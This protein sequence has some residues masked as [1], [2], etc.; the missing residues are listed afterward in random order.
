[1]SKFSFKILATDGNARKGEISTPRGIIRTPAFMPVGTAATVKAMYPEQVRATGADV[2][3]GNTYHLMLRPGAERVER[4]GGLHQFMD[5][6]YPILTDSGGFQVMSLTNLRKLDENGVTFRSHIDGVAHELT[7]ER[8]IDIQIKLDSDII[9]Q[10]DECIK[11]PAEREEIE[12][13]MELSLRWAERSKVAFNNAKEKSN[14]RALFGIVQGGDDMRLRAKSAAGLVNIGFDGYSIGGLAVGEPQEV[15]FKVLEETVP[16]LPQDRPHYLMGVGKPDDI[17]GGIE[18]GIDMFDCVH[19]TRAGRHG[20]V[21]TK[22]GSIN[23]KNSR[24]KDDIRP[25]DETSPN[26]NCTRFSRA[27]L[28][29]LVKSQ[30]ILGAM[31]L[32][33]IN[34]A[35]Y[36]ELTKGAREAI[37]NGTFADF[38]LET[39]ENWQKGDLPQV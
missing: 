27:Y 31:I 21:Y 20:R 17:L 28:H 8:S 22:Y 11:L 30:E 13:A 29:H 14:A 38:V 26:P 15:M 18:R 7:P 36:Q 34:L 16:H 12:R 23:L 10:L 9:M 5:W 19:P 39:R 37:E 3:L 32:S 1:M 24:H 35:Y 4:L 2:L 6:K 33:Q 25:L